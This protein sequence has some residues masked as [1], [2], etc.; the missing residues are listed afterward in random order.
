MEVAA[1]YTLLTMFKIVKKLLK[2]L[3]Y[4]N[5]FLLLKH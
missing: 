1:R 3:C 5:C 2:L 4:S